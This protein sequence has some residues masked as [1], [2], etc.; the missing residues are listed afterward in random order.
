M[1]PMRCRWQAETHV[2]DE[3][4]SDTGSLPDQLINPEEY[5]P[6]LTTAG[7]HT[8]AETTESIE[9]A[10]DPRKLIPMYTYGSFNVTTI[11]HFAIFGNVFPS[12]LTQICCTPNVGECAL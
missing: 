1:L 12:L 3:A 10:N 5:E 2:E 7:K 8:A 6:V 9:P 11:T 4:E